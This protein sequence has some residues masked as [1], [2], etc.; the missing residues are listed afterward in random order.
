[1][2]NREYHSKTVTLTGVIR[3]KQYLDFL[4]RILEEGGSK[5]DRTGTGTKSIFGHQMRF[6]LSDGFPAITTKKIHWPSVIHELLWMISGD[7]NIS[8]LQ[9]NKVRIWNEWADENGDLGPVYGKQWRKWASNEGEIID[10]QQETKHLANFG[11]K[12]LK[13]EKFEKLIE[14]LIHAPELPWCSNPPTTDILL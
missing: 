8:Y 9:H 4:S 12:P 1:M 11:A 13:R 14:R 2:T 7:T 6:D 10:C 5:D 3:M